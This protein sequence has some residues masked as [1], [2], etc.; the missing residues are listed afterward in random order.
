[1]GLVFRSLTIPGLV[2]PW[3]EGQWD[4]AKQIDSLFGATGATILYGGRTTRTLSVP[5]WVYNS[6]TQSQLDAFLESLEALQGSVGT[7]T[8]SGSVSAV[9]PNCCL[10]YVQRRTPRIPPNA[11]IGWSQKITLELRQMAP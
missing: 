5:V 10:D 7:L 11:H 6:Y 9:Y 4:D 3:Q 1:M 8:E 2:E